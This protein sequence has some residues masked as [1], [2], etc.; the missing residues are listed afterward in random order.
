[1]SSQHSG[2]AWIGWVNPTQVPS[3]DCGFGYVSTTNEYKVV[4]S[5]QLRTQFVEVHIYT[6]SSGNGWR[7]LGKF[8][9]EFSIPTWKQGI[10]LNGALYWLDTDSD[11]IISFDLAEEKLCEPL[12]LPPLPRDDEDYYW[13]YD[14]IGL[15]D[16]FLFLAV[17]QN[18]EEEAPFY[19]IWVLGKKN[20][21]PDMKMRQKHQSLVWSKEFK[22]DADEF[23]EFG[24]AV[25]KSGGVLT[26]IDN[27][28]NIYDPKTST[29]KRLVEFSERF[30][31]VVPHMN[32]LVSLKELG[33]EETKVMKSVE[34]EVTE[35]L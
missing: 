28:L 21:N 18:I 11:T 14:R 34:M 29:S 33:E 12:S 5:Y 9:P 23:G 13:K 6:L 20:D 19:D 8:K 30:R 7:N 17:Y 25:T 16:G 3:L 2:W 31:Q 24:V 15:L 1:M 27:H 32:T 26:Y 4:I 35:K 10:Y 22:V